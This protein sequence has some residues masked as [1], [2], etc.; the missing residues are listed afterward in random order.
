ML[1]KFIKRNI[2]AADENGNEVQQGDMVGVAA[3]LSQHAGE[4][5]DFLSG[6]RKLKDHAHHDPKDLADAVIDGV[7]T[8]TQI[9]REIGK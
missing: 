5:A 1:K 6:K 3:V 9:R 4:L 8:M 2:E 7:V